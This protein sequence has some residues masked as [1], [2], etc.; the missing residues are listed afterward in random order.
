[1][2]FKAIQPEKTMASAKRRSKK[3]ADHPEFIE[4]DR[5]VSE[6]PVDG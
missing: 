5:P 1:L 4:G 2:I 6:Q 3:L